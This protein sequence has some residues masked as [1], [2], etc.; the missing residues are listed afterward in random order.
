MYEVNTGEFQRQSPSLCF[1]LWIICSLFCFVGGGTFLWNKNTDYFVSKMSVILDISGS[2]QMYVCAQSPSRIQLCDP[3]DCGPPAS[4]VHEIFQARILE[5]VGIFFS[6]A[7]SWPRDWTRISCLLHWQAHSLPLHHLGNP[8]KQVHNSN[9]F[10][11][12]SWGGK[13]GIFEA[14]EAFFLFLKRGYFGKREKVNAVEG[15]EGIRK[16]AVLHI[17]NRGNLQL[18]L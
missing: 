12:Y 1:F 15:W 13:L 11:S 14:L 6:W 4:T 5:W 3:M 9:R 18:V 7:S 10:V 17:R 2:K 16:I 8:A